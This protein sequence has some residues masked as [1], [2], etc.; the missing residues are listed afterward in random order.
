MAA[1]ALLALVQQAAC[2]H[3]V[4][5]EAGHGFAGETATRGQDHG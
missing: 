5:Q 4:E 1:Q 2:A 3:P